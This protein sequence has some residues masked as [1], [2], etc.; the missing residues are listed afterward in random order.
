MR[1]NIGS[2]YLLLEYTLSTVPVLPAVLIL[3]WLALARLLYIGLSI[4][5]ANL[6]FL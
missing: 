2:N 6:S 5:C 1:A 3:N 4:Y